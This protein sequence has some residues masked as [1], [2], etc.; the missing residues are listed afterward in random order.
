M[1]RLDRDLEQR[2][3]QHQTRRHFFKNCAL[4]VGKIA[5][6]SLLAQRQLSASQP[7]AGANPL[8]PRQPHFPGKARNVIFMFMAGGPS[9]L[10]LFD[11]KPQLQRFHDQPI[12]DSY[13]EG[14]RFAFMDTF[15]KEPPKLLG[16]AREFRQHGLL[17]RNGGRAG[18]LAAVLLASL[19][20][21][22]WYDWREYTNFA[23]PEAMDAAQLGRNIAQG[24]GFTTDFVRPFSLYLVERHQTRTRQRTHDFSLLRS[25]H[26]DLANP[27]LYPLV[28]AGLMKVLP[29]D[30]TIP[31]GVQFR[32]YQ[33][34]VLVAFFNQTLL[35]VVILLV[36]RLAKRLFDSSV[37][38]VS[39]I[40]VAGSD[41]LWK[42]S[43]SGL[44]TLLLVVIF[45]ALVW[46]LAVME[47]A[48]REGRRQT[49]WLARRALLAG[50][51][52]AAGTLTRYSFGWLA[53]PSVIFL[54]AFFPGRR[55]TLSLM[56]AL[57]FGTLLTPWVMRNYRLSGTPFGTTGYALI[58]ETPSCPDARLE[59][60]L[61]PDFSEVLLEDVS[62]KG[63]V[64]LAGI[65]QNDLPKLGGSWI[66][67]PTFLR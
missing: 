51:L 18:G 48:A 22:A 67:A 1:N 9:Q 66:S 65:V 14:K 60:S 42:F 57:V 35:F 37:A 46:C 40:L 20:L 52:L 58:E 47:Q 36:F 11:P 56:T 55:A 2:F 39:A 16:T 38:W 27:P 21:A 44:S 19:A 6:A 10:E 54:A 59:R 29:F 8:A 24:K 26:P 30:Y 32:R 31:A 63:V 34:E 12:P 53:I 43:V 64:N 25:G 23:T 3:L 17:A 7:Q 50:A 28:L 45:L 61:W 49:G 5:L 15:T 33:P 41:M 13:L 62:R 4:G